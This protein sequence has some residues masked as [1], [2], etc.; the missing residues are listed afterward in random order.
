MMS[1]ISDDS[2]VLSGRSG[3]GRTHGMQAGGRGQMGGR[4]RGR[5]GRGAGRGFEGSMEGRGRRQRSGLD[6]AAAEAAEEE[7]EQALPAGR[8]SH[9]ED[10]LGMDEE[11]E[12]HV[13]TEGGSLTQVPLDGEG[14]AYVLDADGITVK[15]LWDSLDLTQLRE[16]LQFE[17]SYSR[18]DHEAWLRGPGRDE[19]AAA[20]KEL[21]VDGFE[22][23]A[24]FEEEVAMQMQLFDRF[25]WVDD[26][27][28]YYKRREAEAAAV[29]DDMRVQHILGS[30]GAAAGGD[31]SGAAVAGEKE[32]AAVAG[33]KE[34]AAEPGATD[35]EASAQADISGASEREQELSPEEAAAERAAWMKGDARRSM[36]EARM[37]AKLIAI[38]EKASIGTTPRREGNEF[39][40]REFEAHVTDKM[41][42][43]VFPDRPR[44]L[45]GTFLSE[46]QAEDA[47]RAMFMES[48]PETELG[49]DRP[50]LFPATS[51]EQLTR[52]YFDAR[53]ELL[54]DEICHPLAGIYTDEDWVAFKDT[55]FEKVPDLMEQRVKLHREQG[56]SG[57]LGG[58]QEEQQFLNYIGSAAMPDDHVA[59]PMLATMTHRIANNPQWKWQEKVRAVHR[60]AHLLLRGER[61]AQRTSSPT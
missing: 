9:P 7:A 49:T 5:A 15:E 47:S 45:D 22:D 53:M 13:A 2:A 57:L 29:A 30:L 34:E 27:Y 4:G 3:R 60:M 12:W 55:V 40:R 17:M 58:F 44:A 21:G 20:R 32:E 26:L 18:A 31:S 42:D 61:F 25:T 8:V 36:R 46:R 56:F 11:P 24:D 28:L 41:M 16:L 14:G 10:G 1:T 39:N 43:L 38:R 51:S 33:E 52:E 23:D 19:M 59:R 48:H 50:E 37:L 35:G 54:R 6:L